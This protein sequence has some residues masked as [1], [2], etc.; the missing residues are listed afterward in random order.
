MFIKRVANIFH[1][2]TSWIFISFVMALVTP[3]FFSS[4]ISGTQ[5]YPIFPF[6]VI[7]FFVFLF[8]KCLPLPGIINSP[9]LSANF[10]LNFT[11]DSEF[12][13]SIWNLFC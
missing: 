3:I 6:F 13:K 5:I 7:H 12:T 1:Q 10:L 2:F 11:F 8:K 9:F 4:L